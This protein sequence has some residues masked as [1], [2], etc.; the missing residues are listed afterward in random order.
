MPPSQARSSSNTRPKQAKKRVIS[1]P[2]G[3]IAIPVR[4]TFTKPFICLA[5][6]DQTIPPSVEEKIQ[7][8][9]AQLGGKKIVFER[10]GNSNHVHQKFLDKFPQ[11]CECGGYGILQL[12][13]GS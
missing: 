5:K 9:L 11:L 2:T 13:V 8:G 3:H 6:K 7:L 12:S 4:D 10:D 1:T